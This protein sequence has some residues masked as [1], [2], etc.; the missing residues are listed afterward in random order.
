MSPIVIHINHQIARNYIMTDQYK[1]YLTQ[2][3]QASLSE[4]LLTAKQFFYIKTCSLSLSSYLFAKAQDFVYTAEEIMAH[5]GP[6]YVQIIVLQTYTIESWSPQILTCIANLLSFF[7]SCCWWGGEKGSHPKMAFT[8]KLEVCEY[9]DAL[10]RIIDYKPL[11]Q[12]IVPRRANDQTI[13]IDAALFG[14]LNIAQH[15]DFI[16][17]LRSKVTLPDTLLTI[18]AA[19]TCDKIPLC[20]YVILGEI[21]SDERLKELKISDSACILFLHMLEQAWKHPSKKFKQ[22]P[23][24]FFFRGKL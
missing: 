22:I 7:C 5:F 6:D 11:Y 1:F 19:S 20:I 13:L 9:I 16:W 8:N 14:V 17:F 24:S 4:S 18:A 21:L 23:I 2:L 15:E 10:I 3:R 12:F